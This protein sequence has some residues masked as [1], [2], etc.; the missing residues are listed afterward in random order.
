MS[1]SK[2]RRLSLAVLSLVMG[3][4]PLVGCSDSKNATVYGTVS[5]DGKPVGYG[6]IR[7]APDNGPGFGAVIRD[8]AY[9][10]ERGV[11]GKAAVTVT[12]MPKPDE[13]ATAEQIRAGGGTTGDE[14][15]PIPAD[16]P[17]QGQTVEIQ[18]GANEVNLD[19]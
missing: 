1:I 10:T 2:P 12:A 7:F 14:F 19:F 13:T 16:H 8:G 4:C 11:P 6:S 18:S 3:L 9:R 15:T 17:K 5:F